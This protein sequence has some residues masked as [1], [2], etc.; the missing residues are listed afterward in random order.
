MADN[1]VVEEIPVAERRRIV[2]ET[3]DYREK[4]VPV[5]CP[6]NDWKGTR[7][8]ARFNLEDGTLIPSLSDGKHGLFLQIQEFPLDPRLQLYISEM[9][10]PMFMEVRA[11]DLKSL[12]VVKVDG[13]DYT[14]LDV[15][16]EFHRCITIS[17][18]KAHG[19]HVINEIRQQM[20][21]SSSKHKLDFQLFVADSDLS[22]DLVALL[23]SL[24]NPIKR[25]W[26]PYLRGP[27]TTYGGL[28][29]RVEVKEKSE[30]GDIIKAPPSDHF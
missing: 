3:T 12:N 17:L 25:P 14:V 24:P 10:Y 29:S 20:L 13:Y 8:A 6:R 4:L 22:H 30:S 19:D 27:L 11:E 5:V 23:E 18:T 21:D 2:P 26:Y 15:Q 1:G 7:Y 28:A 9:E 16:I